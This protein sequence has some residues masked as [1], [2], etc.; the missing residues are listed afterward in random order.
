MKA[1]LLREIADEFLV[2][3]FAGARLEDSSIPSK[4][5]ASLV[6]HH[7]P[8]A[9]KFKVNS[10]DKYKLV[11]T[12][13]QPFTGG[14]VKRVVSEI[15]VV[16]AFVD[17]VASMETELEG[18]LKNDLLSTF[19][20]RIVARAIRGKNHEDVILQGIDQLARWGT[21]LYEGSPIS[22]SLGF[23]HVR[24]KHAIPLTTIGSFDFSAV[25]TNGFDTLMTFDYDGNLIGHEALKHKDSPALLCPMR[26]IYIADWTN[27]HDARV[28]L[29]L[30]RLAEILV[31]RNQ[32]LIFARRSGR[33]HF[34]T[35]EPVISQ[36]RVPRDRNLRAAIYQTCLDASFARTGAC[37]GVVSQEFAAKWPEIVNPDDFHVRPTSSKMRILRRVTEGVTFDK[38]DRRTRQELVAIDGAT[39]VAHD[40]RILAIGAILKVAGGSEGGGRLAA[41]KAL[42]NYGLGLKISQDGGITGFRRGEKGAAFRVM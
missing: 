3:F 26:Q 23:R 14:S 39:L 27:D 6:A 20:R 34:L 41:A 30:N 12:R 24:E 29:T 42:A 11:L 2:P 7:G 22:A 4:T 37:I 16:R 17:V 10:R 25:L 38:L 31:F 15:D 19:Q 13:S 32:Q 33:W 9:I 8:L 21:R 35:H 40:G 28:A 1:A 18:P 5:A 36:M